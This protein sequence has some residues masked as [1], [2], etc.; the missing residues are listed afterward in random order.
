MA[1]ADS[2]LTG[3]CHETQPHRASTPHRIY[4]A[5]RPESVG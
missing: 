1:A 5:A 2:G 4:S 3:G